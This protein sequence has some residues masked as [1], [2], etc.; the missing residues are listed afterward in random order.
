M[1]E[2][3]LTQVR[4]RTLPSPS[5]RLVAAG[6]KRGSGALV[7]EPVTYPPL[8]PAGTPARRRAIQKRGW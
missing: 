2:Q 4:A 8:P 3:K 7:V 5:R 1:A 6:I